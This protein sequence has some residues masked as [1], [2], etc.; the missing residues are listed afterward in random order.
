MLELRSIRR[1]FALG[2]I[3]CVAIPFVVLVPEHGAAWRG[4]AAQIAGLREIPTP[5]ITLVPVGIRVVGPDARRDGATLQ[6]AESASFLAVSHIVARML[7]KPPYGAK[8]FRPAD[9]TAGM[10][11][12]DFV[13]EGEA[14]MVVRR[15]DTYLLRQ[16]RD[17][18]KDLR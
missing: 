12:T 4:D 10:P 18:W 15:G 1:Q 11:L 8:G 14:A 9:Y 13:A 16:E 5:A 6:V 17:A 2:F 3:A 7:A